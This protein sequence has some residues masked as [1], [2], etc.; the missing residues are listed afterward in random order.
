[1]Q[2]INTDRLKVK[3]LWL[4]AIIFFVLLITRVYYDVHH[5]RGMI[6]NKM[7]E[8]HKSIL[9][10]HKE[11]TKNLQDKYLSLSTHYMQMY[12]VHK[13]IKDRDREKLYS[14]LL[15]DYQKFKNHNPYLYVMHFF[16]T[17]NT[18]ILRMHKPLSYGDDLTTIRPIVTKANREKKTF[19]GF[20]AGKNGITY[21]ITS[22]YITKD[23]KHLGVLEF[24]I[25]PQYFAKKLDD[26][27]DVHSEILVKT[28]TLKNLSYKT[29]F[30]RSGDFSILTKDS[31]FD[32]I[33][34]KL[35]LDKEEQ[36]VEDEDKTYIIFNDLNLKDFKN[37]IVGKVIIAKEITKETK[38]NRDSLLIVNGI[39]IFIL[40]SA[41]ILIYMVFT[42]YSNSLKL[43]YE[44]LHE[45]KK[46]VDTDGLT[47]INNRTSLNKYLHNI[48]TSENEYAIIFFDIDLFKEINDSYGHDVGDI[49]LKQLTHL[50]DNTIRVDDFFARWG[51]EEFVIILK[52]N[53]IEKALK[54]TQN[55]RE[56]I[57]SYPYYSDLKVTCSFGVTIVDTPNSFDL[58]MKRVDKLL[59]EAKNSG[60]DC[61]KHDG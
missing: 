51:G 32:T 58:V 53:N 9:I 37:E 44:N 29:N 22:P 13:L 39:N 7:S 36:I 52:I 25:E 46:E 12:D 50:V 56:K 40:S 20:D 18:T 28:S 16:D 47:G 31:F 27:L 49:I 33:K 1:M 42:R 61:I 60:R 19:F 6:N 2:T 17:K 45:L 5:H 11:I 54:I 59:Y 21:R 57:N 41:L 24:G 8:L 3:Y 14:S 43:A 35:D 10:Q 38:E 48:V 34:H 4:L 55:I 30:E 15:Y 26:L 23:G